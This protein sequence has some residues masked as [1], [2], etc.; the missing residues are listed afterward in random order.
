MKVAQRESLGPNTRARVAVRTIT[1]A[2][3]RGLNTPPRRRWNRLPQK[4]SDRARCVPR[5]TLPCFPGPPRWAR[6]WAPG[7]GARCRHRL[8]STPQIDTSNSMT[9]HG[10]ES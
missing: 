9:F 3:N 6:P 2:R 1:E 8:P 5:A 4:R 7:I 10:A